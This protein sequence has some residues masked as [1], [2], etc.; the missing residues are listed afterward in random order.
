VNHLDP[1][2]RTRLAR[3]REYDTTG[4]YASDE[5]SDGTDP[6]NALTVT[7]DPTLRV[8]G[9]QIHR[10]DALR[11]PNSLPETFK[12]A[13][14]AALAARRRG[15]QPAKESA[16][17]PRATSAPLT[18][19]TAPARELLDRHSIRRERKLNPQPGFGSREAAGIS[20]NQ[21]VTVALPPASSAG[22]MA[23]DSGWLQN[24]SASNVA[25]AIVEA[26]TDAYTK[27]DS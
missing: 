2:T 19:S 16:V 26:F 8:T 6:G 9:V 5:P 12:A 3:L 10:I 7:I 24:A 14:A 17:R 4:L 1:D 23:V 15:H 18:L 21:C 25:R 27:R 20:Q 22:S 11:P 13:Y